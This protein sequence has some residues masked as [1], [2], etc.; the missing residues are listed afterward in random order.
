SF[1]KDVEFLRPEIHDSNTRNAHTVQLI[2]L[3]KE[4]ETCESTFHRKDGSILEVKI[5]VWAIQED[6]EKPVYLEGVIE[7]ITE[8]KAMERKLREIE[9][10][11]ESLIDLTSNL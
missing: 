11:H 1:M 5:N 3:A 8:Q 2:E 4:S 9:E 7:D 10:L 6:P